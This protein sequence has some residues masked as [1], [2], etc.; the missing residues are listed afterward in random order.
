MFLALLFH[1][2][3]IQCT[4]MPWHSTSMYVPIQAAGFHE[5]A[6]AILS[7][8]K[9]PW[10]P[11][12]L[13]SNKLPQQFNTLASSLS[14][15]PPLHLYLN[16]FTRLFAV[17]IIALPFLAV[18]K[19]LGAPPPPPTTT[20]TVTTAPTATTISQCNTGDAQCCLSTEA[21]NS[22]NNYSAC[23]EVDGLRR[24]AAT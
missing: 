23:I 19:P 20:V 13:Q 22:T 2:R 17:L 12:F 5:G 18:A 11:P 16:M 24:L 14:A 3:V 10:I 4:A 9:P 7:C 1:S 21:V 8:I 6:R 15:S